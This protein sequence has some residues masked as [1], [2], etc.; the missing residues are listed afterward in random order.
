MIVD[1]DK[2]FGENKM[3]RCDGEWLVCV[4]VFVRVCVFVCDSF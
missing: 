3:G 1:S 2:G 4:S